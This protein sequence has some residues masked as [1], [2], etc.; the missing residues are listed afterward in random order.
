MGE[1]DIARL[2]L[3]HGARAHPIANGLTP[4]AL[5][6]QRGAAAIAALLRAR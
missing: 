3:D 5:A 2:L 4:L 1:L 6:E